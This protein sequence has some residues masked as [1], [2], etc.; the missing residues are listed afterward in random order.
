MSCRRQRGVTLIELILFIM[1]IG[2]AL[3]AIIGVMNVTS[4]RSADPLRAK[5]ALM[6]AEGL[7]EEVQLAAFTRCDP[8]SNE[9]L[10]PAVPPAACNIPEGWG[11]AAP[12]PVGPRPYDNVNDYVAAPN[13][14]TN[15]FTVNNVLLDANGRALNVTGYTATV[16]IT[17][18]SVGPAGALVGNN[19]TAADTDM[20]RIRIAVR[21]DPNETLVLD[22][23]RARYAPGP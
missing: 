20:L 11:Q 14:P 9:P 1:I 12:E 18:E 19:G 16:T 5:Q 15:A 13:V 6:I 2:I 8:T 23:Y 4:S 10:V 21:Y 7:L 22:G 17:P 3:T